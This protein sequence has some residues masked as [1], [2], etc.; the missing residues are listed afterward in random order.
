M[1]YAHETF[2]L[3]FYVVFFLF[4]LENVENLSISPTFLVFIYQN[5]GK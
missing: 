4:N 3:L 1:T 2:D 5:D